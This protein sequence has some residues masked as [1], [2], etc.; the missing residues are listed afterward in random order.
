MLPAQPSRFPDLNWQDAHRCDIQLR[1]ADLDAMGHVN[2]SRY[3]EFLEVARYTLFQDLGMQTYDAYSVL[4][5]LAIDYVHEIRLGQKVVIETL[6][7]KV[8]RTSLTLVSRYLVDSVPSALARGVQVYVDDQHQPKAIS[9]D[10]KAVLLKVL[11]KD[12]G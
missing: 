10:F 8:G 1:Y 6:V 12:V 3:A 5:H 4:A 7:E 9:D 11:V 2:N